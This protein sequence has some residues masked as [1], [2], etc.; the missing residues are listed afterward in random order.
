[1]AVLGRGKGKGVG[2][3]CAWKFGP[4]HNLICPDWSPLIQTARG[5]VSRH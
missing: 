1:M 5:G 2:G 4:P 3:V